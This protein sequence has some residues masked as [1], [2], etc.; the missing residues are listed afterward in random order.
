MQGKSPSDQLVFT[1]LLNET[2][3]QIFFSKAKMERFQKAAE[4]NQSSFGTI[5]IPTW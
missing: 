3:S 5:F 2:F 4:R 1:G